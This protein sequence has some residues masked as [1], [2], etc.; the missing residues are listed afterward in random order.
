MMQRRPSVRQTHHRGAAKTYR[1]PQLQGA[2]LL[3]RRMRTRAVAV[4]AAAV[5]AR[6]GM[7]ALRQLSPGRHTPKGAADELADLRRGAAHLANNVQRSVCGEI[8][9]PPKSAQLIDIPLLDLRRVYLRISA[10]IVQK[11]G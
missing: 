4:A 9:L 8:P 10:S 2:L 5:A 6:R 3:L 7:A 1:V 11:Q